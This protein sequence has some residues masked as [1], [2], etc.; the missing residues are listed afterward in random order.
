M[1][2]IDSKQT[3]VGV[4]RLIPTG[5][6]DYGNLI[7]N[8]GRVSTGPICTGLILLYFQWPG[9]PNIV[10]TLEA[11]ALLFQCEQDEV[12]AELLSLDNRGMADVRRTSDKD[13]LSVDLKFENWPGWREVSL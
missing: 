6:T 2:G 10:F 5:W 4:T 8:I 11:L 3:P 7:Q 12:L 13:L 1:N 9:K